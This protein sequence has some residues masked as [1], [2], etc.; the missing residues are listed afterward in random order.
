MPCLWRPGMGILSK[1][2]GSNCWVKLQQWFPSNWRPL[3]PFLFIYFFFYPGNPGLVLLRNYAYRTHQTQSKKAQR[4]ISIHI[5]VKE[6]NCKSSKKIK[7][8]HIQGIFSKINSSSE[9]LWRPVGK[10]MTYSERWRGWGEINQEVY[11]QENYASQVK[12]KLEHY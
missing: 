4:S 3:L 10:E 1:V 8:H 5:M 7:T 2:R 6:K 11:I 12:V 9:M